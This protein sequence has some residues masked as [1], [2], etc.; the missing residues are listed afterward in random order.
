MAGWAESGDEKWNCHPEVFMSPGDNGV[1]DGSQRAKR[2]RSLEWDSKAS[3]NNQGEKI[4]DHKGKPREGYGGQ[5]KLPGRNQC[6]HTLFGHRTFPSGLSYGF[7]VMKE[8]HLTHLWTCHPQH[9]SLF[10]FFLNSEITD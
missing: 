6:F 9:F 7:L 8:E 5:N 2:E 10:F 3:G 1:D 4:W